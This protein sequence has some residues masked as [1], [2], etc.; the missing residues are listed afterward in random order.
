[1]ARSSSCYQ[2]RGS[3]EGFDTGDVDQLD[4]VTDPDVDG[5]ARLADDFVGSLVLWVKRGLH[6]VYLDVDPAECRT[7]Q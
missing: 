7:I 3:S 2:R 1:M 5:V 6:G 4:V